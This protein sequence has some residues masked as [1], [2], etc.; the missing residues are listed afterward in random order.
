MYLVN[1]VG[2]A[3]LLR[4]VQGKKAVMAD[5]HV[6]PLIEHFRNPGHTVPTQGIGHWGMGDIYIIAF[7]D[8]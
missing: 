7:E 8:F 5:A 2:I 3:D 4:C 1:K 6:H